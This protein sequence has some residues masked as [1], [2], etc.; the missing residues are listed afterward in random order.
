MKLGVLKA[1]VL[2][3]VMGLFSA[4]STDKD[5]PRANGNLTLSAKSTMGAATG[6]MQASTIVISDF[7]VNLREVEFEFDE[8]DPK[9]KSDIAYSDIKLKGA[10]ELDLIN[11]NTSLNQI[12][13]VATLPNARY[14]EVEFKLHKSTASGAM[15]GKSIAISGTIDGVPFELWHDTDEEFEIDFSDMSKDIVVNGNDLALAI[16][17]NLNFLNESMSGVDLSMATDGNGNGVI[18]INP[19]DTDG[20]KEIAHAVKDYLE[21]V[22]DLM[23]K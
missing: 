1:G 20:N 19:N 12:L 23:D 7:K 8:S 4:C 16:D 21:E 9:F 6:R 13:A 3:A 5:E 2:A 10:F 14:E 11:P 17:F 15:L 18:E 22:T